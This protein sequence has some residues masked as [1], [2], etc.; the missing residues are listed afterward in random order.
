MI[1]GQRILA[2]RKLL[3]EVLTFNQAE[4]IYFMKWYFK[5]ISENQK[6]LNRVVGIL[7]K[8]WYKG[9]AIERWMEGY[10]ERKGFVKP[11]ELAETCCNKMRLRREMLP[12]LVKV[13]RRVRARV[14]YRKKVK[15]G[16]LGDINSSETND[17][18]SFLEGNLRDYRPGSHRNLRVKSIIFP[19]FVGVPL[20]KEVRESVR[21]Q[22]CDFGFSL[23]EK[24][25]VD[26]EEVDR[27]MAFFPQLRPEVFISIDRCDDNKF[28]YREYMVLNLKDLI[29][30]GK[31]VEVLSFQVVESEGVKGRGSFSS[32]VS[33][34]QVYFLFR[35]PGLTGVE[36]ICGSSSERILDRFNEM[37]EYLRVCGYEVREFERFRMYRSLVVRQRVRGFEFKGL[38]VARFFKVAERGMSFDAVL[39]FVGEAK[40]GQARDDALVNL[41]SPQG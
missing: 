39:R 36:V 15:G 35:V 3:E 17:N 20:W 38:V 30:Y 41:F 16:L 33:F 12:W 18:Q 6:L 10:L 14:A 32:K 7:N 34:K 31:E 28:E 5:G 9:N 13:A 40:E 27:F 26:E 22:A 23:L 24:K 4:H 25:L 2:L 1:T 11:L 19:N 29:S 8:H 37:G 21:F